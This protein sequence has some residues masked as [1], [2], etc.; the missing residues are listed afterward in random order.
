MK[1]LFVTQKIHG[2]DAFGAQWAEAFVDRGYEV[3]VLCLEARPEEGMQA[4][5][6]TAPFRFTVHSLGKEAGTGKIRQVLRFW[7]L[8][9]TLR[10][11]RV[12]IHMAP[13][14]GLLGAWLWMP[15]RTPVYLWYTHYAMQAGL[16]LLGHYGRRMFCATAQ[17]LPQYEGDPKKV[18]VGHGIDLQFWPRRANV[19]DEPHRL[20]TVHRLA[21]SKRVEMT[22]RA[23]ALLPACTLDIYGIEAEPAYVQ[24]LRSLVEQ[25]GLHARVTFHGTVPMKD[26]PSLYARHRLIVNMATETIDK[27]MLEAMTCGCLPV[28]TARN[29]QAIGLPAAPR[30]DTAES[31]A[32]FIAQSI[33]AAPV[34][35]D[36]LYR[37]VEER[38]SLRSLVE[39]M[40][41]YIRDAR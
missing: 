18:V 25:R 5:G 4:L 41:A 23:L 17:S 6:R 13:V 1:L 40:D 2:Q 37:I 33:N 24:E 21:R 11:D 3:H 7:K 26:L 39:R 16:W 15:K 9:L 30:E 29:A 27:T 34:S 20:L 38:H 35:A 14:W 28:V 31:L 19:C 32:A 10:Y 36:D 22:L 12:F 8:I